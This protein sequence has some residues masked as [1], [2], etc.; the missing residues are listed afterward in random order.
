MPDSLYVARVVSSI[1][2]TTISLACGTNVP[3]IHVL[4]II[5]TNVHSMFTRLGV[6]SLRKGCTFRQPSRT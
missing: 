3:T 6:L 2:A 1:A 5:S 4:L